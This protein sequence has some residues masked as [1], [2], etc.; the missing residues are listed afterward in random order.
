M[1]SLNQKLKAIL[2][3]SPF[4]YIPKNTINSSTHK[5]KK[6]NENLAD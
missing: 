1:K 2:S 6:A 3:D 4:I 5:K